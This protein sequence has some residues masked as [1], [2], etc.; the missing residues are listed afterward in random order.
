MLLS[1]VKQINTTKDG[2]L[3]LHSKRESRRLHCV[4]PGTKEQ[5]PN[6]IHE[7]CG[8]MN[9]NQQ[10][11]KTF[12]DNIKKFCFIFEHQMNPDN[13]WDSF[14]TYAY[15]TNKLTVNSDSIATDKHGANVKVKDLFC[16]LI[17]KR[18]KMQETC[19]VAN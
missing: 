15:H 5:C 17:N 14:V 7:W 9:P 1:C 10:D 19:A 6:Q 12:N 4:L 13:L 16:N 11:G 8:M 18:E 2:Y 3:A